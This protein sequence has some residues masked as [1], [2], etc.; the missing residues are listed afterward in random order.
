MNRKITNLKFL[1]FTLIELLIVVAIIG[2]LAAIAIPNF[3]QA[4]VRA[5]VAACQGDMRSLGLAVD[6]YQVDENTYPPDWAHSMIPQPQLM[7]ARP[8]FFVLTTPVEYVSSIPDCPFRGFTV[9]GSI[10]AF[11]PPGSTFD[12][13]FYE[14]PWALQRY[15]DMGL[16]ALFPYDIRIYKYVIGAPGPDMV[17]ESGG[18]RYDP[19]NGTVSV[20]NI[21]RLGP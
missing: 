21:Y 18:K 6:I 16:A 2:I 14:G 15:Q 1:G 5:K 17:F 7:V 13:Y 10:A 8:A 4:Q 3:L 12:T 11:F 20:G 9:G 19:T